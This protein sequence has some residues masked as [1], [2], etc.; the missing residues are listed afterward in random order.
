MRG[1]Q[2][3]GDFSCLY[4]SV[5]LAQSGVC[6]TNVQHARGQCRPVARLRKDLLRLRVCFVQCSAGGWDNSRINQ[7]RSDGRKVDY[8]KGSERC[9]LA[10][11]SCER[12]GN[13]FPE[14]RPS[15]SP[16]DWQCDNTLVGT[17][18]SE[19]ETIGL[20]ENYT[21]NEVSRRRTWVPGERWMRQI[22][23]INYYEAGNYNRP[24]CHRAALLKQ[25]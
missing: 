8:I 25:M 24:I 12:G 5:V 20:A 3:R 21:E 10:R 4:G 23:C 15:P 1:V 7:V 19:L 9:L 2:T 11:R 16:R 13:P 18:E 17:N 22:G 6:G 14:C